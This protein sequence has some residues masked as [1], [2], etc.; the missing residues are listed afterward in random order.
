MQNGYSLQQLKRYLY[1]RKKRE[2]R[3]KNLMS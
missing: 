3:W 1:H 2:K